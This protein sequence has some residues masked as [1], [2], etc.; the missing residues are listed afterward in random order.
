MKDL[1]SYNKQPTSDERDLPEIKLF[2]DGNN[3]N[4]VSRARAEST[5]GISKYGNQ[6]M[7]FYVERAR[8]QG[9]HVLRPESGDPELGGGEDSGHEVAY[10]ERCHLDSDL[11]DDEGL[12]SV[13]EE[14]VE[15]GE[16]GAG[17]EAQEPHSEGPYGQRRVVVVGHG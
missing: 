17:E 10:G 13:V 5:S 8:I 1:G 14:L 4:S 7:L 11:G 2:D 16:E 12:L 15:K 3:P 6:H 9:N